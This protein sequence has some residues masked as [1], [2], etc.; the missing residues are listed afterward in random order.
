MILH[1]RSAQ[2]MDI[3]GAQSLLAM[4]DQMQRKNIRLV[5]AELC[6]QPLQLL[7]KTEVLNI[8]GKDNIFGDFKEAIL[9]VNERLLKTSCHGCATALKPDAT[10][11]VHGPKDCLLRRAIVLNTDKIGNILS[12]RMSET[13]VSAQPATAVMPVQ[14]LDRLITIRSAGDIPIQFKNTPIEELLRAQNMYDVGYDVSPS[15]SLIVGMCIDNRKQLHLPKNGAYIIRSPGANMRGQESS[16]VLALTAG[17]TYMALIVHNQCLMS[18]PSA[19][20]GQAEQVL[21]DKHGWTKD[22]LEN[23][24]HYLAQCQIG[25]PIS[26]ALRETERLHSLFKGLTVVP[27]LYDVYSDHL[28]IIKTN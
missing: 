19:K 13:A 20:K 28:S 5:L 9:A 27:I 11:A 8:I 21:F 6:E 12:E 23:A 25:D 3:T 15:P 24:F 1:M 7:E 16:I 18:N 4:H 14:D 2:I 26:F 22:Q 10:T 17:I